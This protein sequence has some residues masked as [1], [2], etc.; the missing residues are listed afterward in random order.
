MGIDWENRTETCDFWVGV[1]PSE[2][3]F[4]EYVGEDDINYYKLQDTD[5]AVPL[6]RFIHDQG[7]EWYDHDL[8]EMGFKEHA[9]SIAELV[10]GYS[11]SDQYAEELTRRVNEIGLTGVNGFLFIR[12]G[13]ISEPRTAKTDAF[14]FWYVGRIT[15]KI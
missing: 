3:A 4:C 7:E 14:E 12:S 2:E 5:N 15:Y 11:Y 9:G 1:F 13:E 10:K 8:I 6:S